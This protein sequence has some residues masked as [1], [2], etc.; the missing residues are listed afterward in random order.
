MLL[1]D[2]VSFD[3]LDELCAKAGAAEAAANRA[4]AAKVGARL[5]MDDSF[6]RCGRATWIVHVCSCIRLTR[7]FGYSESI[8]ILHNLQSMYEAPRNHRSDRKT[9]GACDCGTH[10]RWQVSWHPSEGHRI[11]LPGPRAM[12]PRLAGTAEAS[13][14]PAPPLNQCPRCS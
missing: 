1:W 5:N 11:I 8:Q 13:R 10:S 7:R 12:P 4:T 9:V 6:R 3:M 14:A 2:I